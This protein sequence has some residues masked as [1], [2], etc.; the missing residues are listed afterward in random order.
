VEKKGGPW[1]RKHGLERQEKRG[2]VHERDQSRDQGTSPSKETKC[3]KKKR[4]PRAFGWDQP[5]EEKKDWDAQGPQ[6]GARLS[7]RAGD[8][9]GGGRNPLGL[10]GQRSTLRWGDLGALGSNW[11]TP[12]KQKND[13]SLKESTGKRD[14]SWGQSKDSF[15][16]S[17]TMSPRPLD[18]RVW[19]RFYRLGQ[20]GGEGES[21]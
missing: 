21:C 18:K 17:A 10:I 11:S 13:T 7:D 14:L 8:V 2:K 1:H 4:E 12:G 6:R 9:V 3:E 19:D 20:A 16:H 5:G 15:S